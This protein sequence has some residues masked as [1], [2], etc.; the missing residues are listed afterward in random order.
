MMIGG[1]EAGTLGILEVDVDQIVDLLLLS[2]GALS[3]LAK[4]I[5]TPIANLVSEAAEMILNFSEV[6][7]RLQQIKSNESNIDDTTTPTTSAQLLI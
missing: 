2:S 4:R 3:S 5:N 1:D 7:H 6:H